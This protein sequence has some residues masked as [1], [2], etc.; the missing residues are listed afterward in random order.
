MRRLGALLGAV[1]MVVAAFAVRGAVT[2]DEVTRGAPGD[3]VS[4]LLCPA[5]FEAV[6]DAA[7]GDVLVE[8][9]GVTADRL[10]AAT[11]VSSLDAEAWIIPAAWA[12]LVVAERERLRREPIFEVTDE[13]IATSPV[14]LAA[15]TEEATELAAAC[16]VDAVGWG[17]IAEQTG[18]QVLGTRV[19]SGAPPVESAT[20]LVVAAGQ[21]GALLGRS[22]YATNDFTPEFESAA[23]RLAAGQVADPLTVMR[24]RGRGQFTAVGVVGADAQQIATTFGTIVVFDDR[25]PR[26]RAD[27]VALVPAG[28]DI[29]GDRRTALRAAFTAAGWKTAASGADGLPDGGVLAAVRALWNS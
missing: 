22:D 14:V 8:P 19:Q 21:A 29:D 12:R 7:G 11:E 24:T 6:C 25:E 26:V 20:G 15:W 1:V 28:G 18:Q 17:C 16:G 4:G 5:E 9:A 13:L 2:D 3:D 10:I 23:S 27:V